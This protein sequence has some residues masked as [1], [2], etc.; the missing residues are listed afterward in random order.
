MKWSLEEENILKENYKVKNKS[1][2]LD[3]FPNRT[4]KAI[5]NKANSMNIKSKNDYEDARGRLI[6]LAT[7][8]QNWINALEKFNVMD[9]YIERKNA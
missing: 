6:G 7:N 3:L 5:K 9:P 8:R 4:W 1:E 2:L